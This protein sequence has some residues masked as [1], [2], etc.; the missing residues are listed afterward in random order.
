IATF[1]VDREW[2]FVAMITA[3]EGHPFLTVY[4]L[5]TL[6]A[7]G[8]Q[9]AST[10]TLNPYPGG[11]HLGGWANNRLLYALSFGQN[12]LYFSTDGP[13]NPKEAATDIWP[14]EK[15]RDFRLNPRTMKLMH[16]KPVT[17]DSDAASDPP[18]PDLD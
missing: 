10:Y 11:V 17:A 8:R 13:V 12:R 14:T 6:I 3:E 5:D 9:P 16:I 1:E 4:N 18:K 15:M 2:R 7:N